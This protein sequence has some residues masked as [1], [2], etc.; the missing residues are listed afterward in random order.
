MMKIANPNK[1]LRNLMKKTNTKYV[2]GKPVLV[3]VSCFDMGSLFSEEGRVRFFTMLNA[4]GVDSAVLFVN[5]DKTSLEYGQITAVKVGVTQK[6]KTVQ[7]CNGKFIGNPQDG[8][9]KIAMFFCV[10]A[11]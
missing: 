10:K 1:A 11:G 2:E 6:I 7:E 5:D 9:A 4:P 8:T 3:K